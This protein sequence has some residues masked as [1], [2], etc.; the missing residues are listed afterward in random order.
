MIVAESALQNALIAAEKQGAF[1]LDLQQ[2]MWQ[3]PR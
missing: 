1:L 2:R 3:Y